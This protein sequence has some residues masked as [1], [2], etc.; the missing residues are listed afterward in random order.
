MIGQSVGVLDKYMKIY[1]FRSMDDAGVLDDLNK[2]EKQ[3]QE[4]DAETKHAIVI[5]GDTLTKICADESL[6][7]RF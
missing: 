7:K 6:T 5:E 4:K 2:A 3:F 1:M